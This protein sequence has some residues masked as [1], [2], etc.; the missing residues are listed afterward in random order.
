MVVG[1]LLDWILGLS[2]YFAITK[3]GVRGAI[4]N[5]NMWSVRDAVNAFGGKERKSSPLDKQTEM[6]WITTQVA[7]M[8]PAGHCCR[9]L[10]AELLF[11]CP[12]KDSKHAVALA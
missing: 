10:G 7:S 11:F 4:A 8:A 5:P 9:N 3:E 6:C 2:I 12:C 1:G